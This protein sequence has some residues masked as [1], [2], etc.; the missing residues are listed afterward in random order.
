MVLT[1][2][3]PSMEYSLLPTAYCLLPTACYL[4]PVPYSRLRQVV[5]KGSWEWEVLYL[6][7]TRVQVKHIY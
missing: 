1:A 7:Y 6:V 3:S 2:P 5:D 4:L